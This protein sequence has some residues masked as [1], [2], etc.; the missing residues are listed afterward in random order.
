MIWRIT[1]GEMTE[2]KSGFDRRQRRLSHMFF[3]E[4]FLDGLKFTM[5]FLGC[6]LLLGGVGVMGVYLAMLLQWWSIPLIVL[7]LGLVV[8]GF[9]ALV[10][11]VD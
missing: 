1:G 4:R 11:W 3:M 2:T 10:A 6:I 5:G 8:V 7:L 9:S